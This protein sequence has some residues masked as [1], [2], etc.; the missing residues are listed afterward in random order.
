MI[1][2][3]LKYYHPVVEGVLRATVETRDQRD[4]RKYVRRKGKKL[5]ESGE[6]STESLDFTLFRRNVK[7]GG[8]YRHTTQAASA[9][10]KTRRLWQEGEGT[11]DV[12]V[13][14]EKERKYCHQR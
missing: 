2:Q 9:R 13:V 4:P 12:S 7:Y 1:Y 3:G 11:Y 10:A 8:A 6:L 5:L 14:S